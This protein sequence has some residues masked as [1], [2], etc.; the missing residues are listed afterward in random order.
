MV[1]GSLQSWWISGA[2]TGD[3][4]TVGMCEQEQSLFDTSLEVASV[5]VAGKPAEAE[6]EAEAADGEIGIG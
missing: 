5:G 2:G 6:A 4:M 3:Q 1:E